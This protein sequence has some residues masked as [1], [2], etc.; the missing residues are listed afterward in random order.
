MLANQTLPQLIFLIVFIHCKNYLK[1]WTPL[2]E[3]FLFEN[4]TVVSP[5]V[6]T[7]NAEKPCHWCELTQLNAS[8]QMFKDQQFNIL[9]N[10]APTVAGSSAAGSVRR[11]LQFVQKAELAAAQIMQFSR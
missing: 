10:Q 1:P 7:H 8:Q 4:V 3:T 2:N 9:E 5:H 6:A 11:Q